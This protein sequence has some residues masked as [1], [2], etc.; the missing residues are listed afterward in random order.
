MF[1]KSNRL[2]KNIE[3]SA[4]IGSAYGVISF[5]EEDIRSDVSSSYMNPKV[6]L[7]NQ[8]NN[9]EDRTGSMEQ[10]YRREQE[11]PEHLKQ[12]YDS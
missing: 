12:L 11:I 5:P 6:S 7:V 9:D 3:K 1:D 8:D 4:V 2:F 10:E